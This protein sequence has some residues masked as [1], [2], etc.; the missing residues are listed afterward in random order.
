MNSSSQNQLRRTQGRI[1]IEWCNHRAA[2]AG[3]LEFQEC[4][5][6]VLEQRVIVI[7]EANAA[8]ATFQQGK[9]PGSSSVAKEWIW[10]KW[11]T[12][13]AEPRSCQRLQVSRAPLQGWWHQHSQS[14]SQASVT[15]LVLSLVHTHFWN[16][17]P[18]QK[19]SNFILKWNETNGLN[20]IG[21][22]HKPDFRKHHCTIIKD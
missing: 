6:N 15:A 9:F 20:G 7:N 22:T 17:K 8:P 1:P 19:T 18:F 3:S 13:S 16:Q 4:T 10:A 21:Q 5:A 12:G 11:D 14:C 2:A